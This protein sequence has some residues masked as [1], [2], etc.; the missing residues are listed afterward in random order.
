MDDHIHVHRRIAT[1]VLAGKVENRVR[2][3]AQVSSFI[4]QQRAQMIAESQKSGAGHA[5][6]PPP[7]GGPEGMEAP[8]SWSSAELQLPGQP[9]DCVAFFAS[10]GECVVSREE[11]NLQ[12]TLM[13]P[14]KELTLD[15]ARAIVL[16]KTLNVR[17]LADLARETGFD[18]LPDVQR[19]LAQR[20]KPASK[21]PH[22]AALLKDVTD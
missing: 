7:M 5:P 21:M 8:Q 20:L 6:P 2:I 17:Y 19:K 11:F 18:Q 10:S 12:T 16:D 4:E 13:T 1:Q 15:S 22:N 14:S 3:Q 9:H